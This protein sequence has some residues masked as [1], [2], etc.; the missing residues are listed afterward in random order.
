MKNPKN[1]ILVA[2]VLILMVQVSCRQ[3][4]PAESV[5]TAITAN[6]PKLILRGES[7]KFSIKTTPGIEC[8][9]GIGYYNIEDKWVFTKL[10][11]LESDKNGVCEWTWEV[12]ADAKD[13]LGG[14]KGYVQEKDR[15]NDIFPAEFC[16]ERCP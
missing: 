15:S 10:P 7:Q 12:P 13:G 4:Y 6:V 2:F 8:Y 14:F 11:K 5:P 9:A 1:K 16:I 3:S